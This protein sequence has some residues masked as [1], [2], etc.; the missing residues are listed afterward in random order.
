MTFQT[1]RKIKTIEMIDTE[2][3]PYIVGEVLD[4]SVV[5]IAKIFGENGSP[6]ESDMIARDTQN[7]DDMWLISRQ[8]FEENYCVISKPGHYSCIK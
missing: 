7:H 5:E 3:R 8:Y 6:K 4:E 2:M 1:Y